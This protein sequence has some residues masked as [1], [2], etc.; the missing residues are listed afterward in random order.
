M[1]QDVRHRVL[2]LWEKPQ[3]AFHVIRKLI[4]WVQTTC[5]EVAASRTDLK[6][7]GR[8]SGMG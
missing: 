4:A 8:A 7:E 1:G 6:I 2:V 3:C 5:S